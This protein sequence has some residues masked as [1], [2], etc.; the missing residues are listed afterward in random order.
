ML[1]TF[2]ET[3]LEIKAKL[4]RGFSDSSRLSILEVLRQGPRSVGE[5]VEL[6]GLSQSNTSNHLA[7][8]RDCGLVIAQQQGRYVVYELSDPR[9]D[10]LL[11][12]GEALLRDVA[13]GVYQCT[14]YGES[15]EAEV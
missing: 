7:C 9:V 12:L 11:A 6:T 15:V 4:F 1:Q 3:G 10:E 8:L 14:R 13:R 2:A 5:I